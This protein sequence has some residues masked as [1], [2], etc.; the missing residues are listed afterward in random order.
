MT[1][2][3]YKLAIKLSALFKCVRGIISKARALTSNYVNSLQV[4]SN[5]LI[6]RRLVKEERKGKER[7]SYGK[8]TFKSLSFELT[9][10]FG[11]GYS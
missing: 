8:G 11:C 2:K 3:R 1:H 4:F 6:G 9:K 10:E 7:A 5:Y